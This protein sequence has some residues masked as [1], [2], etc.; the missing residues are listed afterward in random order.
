MHKIDQLNEKEIVEYC[1]ELN[2]EEF[3]NI[4]QLKNYKFDNNLSRNQNVKIFSDKVGKEN[5]ELNYS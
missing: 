3:R 2:R 4:M 1:S 5:K